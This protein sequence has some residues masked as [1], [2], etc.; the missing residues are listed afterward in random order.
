VAR[1]LIDVA[2]H[3]QAGAIVIGTRRAP[4]RLGQR[5]IRS[6][7]EAGPVLVEALYGPAEQDSHPLATAFDDT[8]R[9]GYDSFPASDPPPSWAGPANGRRRRT[10]PD[11]GA[12]EVVTQS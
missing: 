11:A 1:A 8:H 5:T 10:E 7:L 12:H 2:L 9:Y 4:T 3:T 6:E